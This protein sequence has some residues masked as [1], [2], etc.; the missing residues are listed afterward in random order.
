MDERQRGGHRC[1]PA[2]VPH[3]N[4]SC[5]HQCS[6]SQDRLVVPGEAWV[7]GMASPLM[8]AWRTVHLSEPCSRALFSDG[9]L[10]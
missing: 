10:S 3:T 7:G 1:D 2:V 9:F 6:V 8:A 5:E 4:I